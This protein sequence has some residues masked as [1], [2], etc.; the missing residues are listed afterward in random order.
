[1]AVSPDWDG[2]PQWDK[3]PE[4]PAKFVEYVDDNVK[5]QLPAGVEVQ[6]IHPHGAS[7]W[8]RLAKLVCRR[9]HDGSE[10]LFFLK[11]SVS[12]PMLRGEY[13]SMA[14]LHAA[15]PRLVPEPLG[16]GPYASADGVHFL[17]TAFVR[18]D[19]TRPLCALDRLPAALAAL[20][21]AAAAAVVGPPRFGFPVPT[22]QGRL[23]GD[24][25]WCASWEESFRR[26]LLCMFAHE[27]AAQGPLDAELRALKERVV[28]RVL[29]RL[30]AP[31]ESGGRKVA[32]VLVHGDLWEGNT[33]TE[34][35]SG[36][37]KIFDACSWYAHNEFELAPWRPKRQKMNREYV[38]EYLKHMPPSEPAEDFDG[39][40]LLYALRFNLCSSA[41]YPGNPHYREIVRS[42]M[43]ELVDA[44][45]ESFEEW[46]IARKETKKHESGVPAQSG[47][48]GTDTT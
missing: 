31:L 19:A 12:G 3:E 5:S 44:Y 9:Q 35:G 20:H 2:T 37:P 30:L 39:R 41:L 14:A 27:E 23:P 4:V 17:L 48:V 22:Y 46:Q 36:D 42:D 25:G 21:R 47:V 32:P 8:T 6:A 13:E 10:V 1:M 40:N 24:A 11:V 34:V 38:D 26:N 15:S 45:P 29:P 28:R 7:F 18:M 43:R 33:G 16:W